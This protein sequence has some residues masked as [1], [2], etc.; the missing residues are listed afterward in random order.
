MRFAKVIATAV[1]AAFLVAS[2]PVAASAGTGYA[3][4][5]TLT[6]VGRGRAHGVGLCMT[7]VMNMSR[8]GYK[9]GYILPYFYRGARVQYKRIPNRVRVGV[10]RRRGTISVTG[11]GYFTVRTPSGRVLLRGGS[12]KVVSVYRASGGYTVLL[13]RSGSIIAR[14]RSSVPVRVVPGSGTLLRVVNDGHIYRGTIELRWGSASGAMWAVNIVPIEHYLRGLGEEPE[15]WPYEGLKVLAIVSRSYAA[16]RALNPKH[17]GDGFAICNTGDC[18]AYV[19]YNYERHAPRLRS[20]VI[21]TRGRVVTYGGRLVVTPYFSNS[22]GQTESIQYVWG[23]SAKAW[24]RSVKTRWAT[25]HVAYSWTIPLTFRQLATR[26]SHSSATRLRGSLIGFTVLSTG[27]SPRICTMRIRDTGGSRV[28]TGETFRTVASLQSTWFRFDMPPRITSPVAS[29]S[30]LSPDGDGVADTAKM[31]LSISER[32]TLYYAVYNS[33]GHLVRTAGYWV[34]NAGRTSLSWDGKDSSGNAVPD[35]RYR[36]I[37][38]ARD[39]RRNRNYSWVW[40]T[41]N[42]LLSFVSATPATITP[43]GDS[44]DDTSTVSFRLARQANVN[45]HVD[46]GSG[47]LVRTLLNETSG[48]GTR[49]VEWDGKN[50]GGTVV[51]AGTYRYTVTANDGTYS[52]VRSGNIVVAASLPLRLG[53]AVEPEAVRALAGKLPGWLV[54]ART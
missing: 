40:F 29:P 36:L 14:R 1:V 30:T 16:Y 44:V 8:A 5:A 3:T 52:S 33:G 42:R 28:V 50:D 46:D 27:V 22:G 9:Y 15:S 39:A 47:T 32:A 4:N 12:G 34:R 25:G 13:T 37:A 26:L 38:T 17:S 21:G 11:G 18:Q 31:Y 41:S 24:L 43:N 20:A 48:A 7:S 23:G 10:Y 49:R 19:G 45:V 2:M 6:I 35:G 53:T 54:P 51:P